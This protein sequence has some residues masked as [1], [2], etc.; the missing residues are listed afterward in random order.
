MPKTNFHGTQNSYTGTGALTT[1]VLSKYEQ[2]AKATAM[3]NGKCPTVA[4]FLLNPTIPVGL[5]F[6]T[7]PLSSNLYFLV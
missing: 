2:P 4:T 3:N 6:E 1:S 7:V 5:N